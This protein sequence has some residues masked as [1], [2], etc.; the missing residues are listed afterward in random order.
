MEHGKEFKKF[1]TR[2]I[3]AADFAR[4][5]NTG[6]Q[7]VNSWFGRGLPASRVQAAA[8]ALGVDQETLWRFVKVMRAGKS[9][10]RRAGEVPVR[11]SY[12]PTTSLIGRL[13]SHLTHPCEKK[14]CIAL[15]LR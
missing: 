15:A 11:H 10:L 9:S 2:R 6:A 4:L 7:T 3:K 8:N 13:R 1:L 12:H 14:I 5:M